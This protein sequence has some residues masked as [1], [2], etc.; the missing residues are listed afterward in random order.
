VTG[1]GANFSGTL[2][3]SPNLKVIVT[4]DVPVGPTF[5]STYPSGSEN[6]VGPNGLQNL[7]NYA[8]GGT[9]PGSTP[10]LPVLTSDGTNLSLTAN[11]RN[12]GQGVGVVGQY[13]YTLDGPWNDV[14]LTATGA[15]ST[16]ANTTVKAFSQAIETGQPRKFLR[17]KATLI[18]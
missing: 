8:L 11:I 6:T 12:D 4:S 9:G 16:V 13:A 10:A 2:T 5:A 14:T 15:T 17:F 7:M 3:N 1:L 18:P